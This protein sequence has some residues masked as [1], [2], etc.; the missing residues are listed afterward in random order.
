MFLFKKSKGEWF[1]QS[2]ILVL[3]MYKKYL[4]SHIYSH[5]FIFKSIVNTSSQ[6]ETLIY[7][8]VNI[9]EPFLHSRELNIDWVIANLLE[10]GNR[11]LM[12]NKWKAN[13]GQLEISFSLKYSIT[14]LLICQYVHKTYVF[15]YIEI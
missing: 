5:Y 13:V 15:V 10:W 1:L 11:E 12:L 3:S 9:S 8:S 6:W 7:N 4:I 14:R 2:A